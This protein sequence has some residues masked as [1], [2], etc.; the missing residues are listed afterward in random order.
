MAHPRALRGGTLAGCLGRG[1]S[2]SDGGFFGGR[3]EWGMTQ[4]AQVAFLYI[5]TTK[6]GI[7]KDKLSWGLVQRT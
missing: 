3:P 5:F 6:L 7:N 2:E 4:C 1:V